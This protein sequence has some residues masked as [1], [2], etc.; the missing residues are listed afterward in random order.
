MPTLLVDTIALDWLLRDPQQL[1]TPARTQIEAADTVLV[2]VVS[3]WE[4]AHH[5]RDGKLVIDLAFD[6]YTKKA[7]RQHQLTLWP[8]QW[9]A[10]S[11]MSSFAYQVIER[12]WSQTTGEKTVQGIKRDLHKD[13]FDRMLLAHAL[14]HQIP[15]VSPNQLFPYYQELGLQLVW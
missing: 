5:V 7:L 10:L 6:T 11:Y 8:I 4:L 12:P 1:S 14:S 15:I 13:P 3:L 9:Q 2:S